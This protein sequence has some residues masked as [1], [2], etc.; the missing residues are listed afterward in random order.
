MSKVIRELAKNPNAFMRFQAT[1]KLPQEHKPSGPL[2]DLL[3]SI[4]PRDLGRLE[5]V[6]VGPSLGYSGSRQF[7]YGSQALRWIAPAGDNFRP[8]PSE[9]WKMRGFSRRLYIEDLLESCAK[10]PSDFAEK[11]PHLR[12]PL[13]RVGPLSGSPA[14]EGSSPEMGASSD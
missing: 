8:W 1:G 6:K 11:Y 14:T 5:G 13:Q 12:R 3:K 2:Y 4:A 7:S 9:S 10:A